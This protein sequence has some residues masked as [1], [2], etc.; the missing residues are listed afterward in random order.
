MVRRWI[1]VVAW[2]AVFFPSIPA[3]AQQPA[4]GV[5]VT[6]TT[7]TRVMLIDVQP[8]RRPDFDQ[9]MIENMIPVYEAQKKAGI[10]TDY[11]VFNN[12]TTDSA[13][14]WN[15]GIALTYPNWAVLDTLT[16]RVN[17]ITLKHYGTVEKRQAAAEKRLEVGVVVSSRLTRN[18]RYSRGT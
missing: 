5:V 11:Q 2:A 18:I 3:G 4:A 7:V 14:D 12:M 16:S 9:D 13:T 17:E 10:L 6:P 15:V 1:V 8:G